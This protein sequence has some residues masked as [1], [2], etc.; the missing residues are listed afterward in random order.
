MGINRVQ[1][2]FV[3]GFFLLLTNSVF[4][5]QTR[6]FPA[7][8]NGKKLV[9]RVS[10]AKNTFV[11][12]EPISVEIWVK[13]I[14]TDTA[15]FLLT[16]PLGWT[17]LGEEDKSYKHTDLSIKMLPYHIKPGD[18]IGGLTKIG[19][20]DMYNP[21]S[22]SDLFS[23]FP[24][25]PLG[26]YRAFFGKDTVPFLFRV[27][28]DSISKN[29]LRRKKFFEFLEKRQAFT[30]FYDTLWGTPTQL[31]TLSEGDLLVGMK[32]TDPVE[33]AYK[34]FDMNKTMFGVKNPRAE[35]KVYK[36]T[37]DTFGVEVDFKQ[38]YRGLETSKDYIIITRFSPD[39]E[40]QRFSG[41][42]YP[43]ISLSIIPEIS[44]S[45]A[46]EIAKHDLNLQN[47][48]KYNTHIIPEPPSLMVLPYNGKYYLAWFIFINQ[49]RYFID[50]HTGNTIH[51]AWIH[52]SCY[53]P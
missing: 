17:V 19:R 18:S 16:K 38:F 8:Y 40:L 21:E 33:S 11:L 15:R 43:D 32:T 12:L 3:I 2:K 26:T 46:L 41:T 22:F 30:Q 39:G 13:N 49:W 45:G 1:L 35:L 24:Y 7:E 25:F 10:L 48:A 34:F 42:F 36:V 47:D 27:V 6:T 50:A 28:I 53:V 5:Q 52:P 23:S 4:S 9:Y 20:L 14:S 29:H 51:K 44:D 31:E 37:K